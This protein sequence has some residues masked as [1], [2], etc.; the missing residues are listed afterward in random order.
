VAALFDDGIE[1]Q[2]V[3][4]ALDPGVPPDL[5][6][7]LRERTQ[8]GDG[9]LRVRVVTVSSTNDASGL[10]WRLELHT[11]E[12]LAGNRP[13]PVDLPLDVRGGTPALSSRP[14]RRPRGPCGPCGESARRS[15][16]TATGGRAHWHVPRVGFLPR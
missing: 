3:G 10:S 2:A 8:L 4:Y 11:L 14:G 16:L 12:R 5:D 1:P 6:R 7:S 15:S 13:P 9:V